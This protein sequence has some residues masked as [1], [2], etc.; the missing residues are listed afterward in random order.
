MEP[1]QAFILTKI[2]DKSPAS[3]KLTKRFMQGLAEPFQVC[4]LDYDENMVAATGNIAIVEVNEFEFVSVRL[5]ASQPKAVFSFLEK[6]TE[7]LGEPEYFSVD[8]TP[9][10]A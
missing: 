8:P 7:C 2:T 10:L 4:T 1:T 3:R 6:L 5:P 9:A